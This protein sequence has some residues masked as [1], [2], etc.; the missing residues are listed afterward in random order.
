MHTSE[1]DLAYIAGII[2][3][4]GCIGV[5]K[6]AKNCNQL[7][8]MVKMCDP[9]AVGAI[10]DHFGSVCS[11]YVGENCYVYRVILTGQRA[12]DFLVSIRKYL[13]VKA[14][15][16]DWAIEFFEECRVGK[17]TKLTPEMMIK[18]QDYETILKDLKKI[19]VW[20]VCHP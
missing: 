2:D 18:R 19:P 5:Y 4:E 14:E 20:E 8:V 3:G 7:H 12:Y 10:N 15:Q 6:T 13:R 11:G 9:E 1:T 17:G 16:A